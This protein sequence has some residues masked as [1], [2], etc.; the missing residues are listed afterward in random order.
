MNLKKITPFALSSALLATSAMGAQEPP[1]PVGKLTVD[2]DLIRSGGL[3]TLEWEV[4]HPRQLDKL[5]DISPEDEI[6]A[7]TKLRVKVSVIGVGLTDQF[8][9]EYKASS[10]IKFNGGSWVSIF[11]GVGSAVD[12]S[13]VHVEQEIEA[14]STIEFAA[15]Y[16]TWQYNDDSTITILRDGDTPPSNVA[17]YADQASAEE[18][19]QPYIENGKISLGPLDLIY[20]AELTHT[21]TSQSGYDMQDTIVLLRFEEIESDLGSPR[22]EVEENINGGHSN[23][24]HGNNL[25][26]V[27]VS[28]PG[29]SKEGE[30][31]DTSI[32]DEIK[33]NDVGNGGCNKNNHCDHD[34][35]E[36]EDH[37]RSNG[38]GYEGGG[39]GNGNQ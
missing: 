22:G 16:D 12:P 18:F 31:T 2:T 4:T 14:G 25:D 26:G 13:V 3:P 39:H 27:D 19:I 33:G 37:E 34:H 32:D 5:I 30:D 1:I 10:S 9:K 8:G 15:K 17:G 36:E 20:I 24:G 6:T 7:K 28:N 38:P 23:N 29:N 21:N 11:K 35:D